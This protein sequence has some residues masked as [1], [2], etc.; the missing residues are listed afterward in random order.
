MITM[1]LDTSLARGAELLSPNLIY[2]PRNQIIM[3]NA[4][5]PISDITTGFV[6]N[7]IIFFIS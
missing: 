4:I 7:W 1:S 3:D 2:G 5:S 6:K